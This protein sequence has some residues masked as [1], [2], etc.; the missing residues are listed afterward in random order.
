MNTYICRCTDNFFFLDNGECKYMD[1][2]VRMYRG[3]FATKQKYRTGIK[4]YPS[5]GGAGSSLSKPCFPSNQ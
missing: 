4:T 1:I 2:Y 5:S 3:G